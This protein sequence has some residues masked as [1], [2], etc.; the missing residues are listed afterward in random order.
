MRP[1]ERIAQLEAENM[2]QREQIAA[3][4]VR[5]QELEARLAKDSHNSSKP[6]SSDGLARKAKS[7]RKRS[8]K[9]AGGQIGHR[10]QT[11]RLVAVP[12]EIVE[13]RP[14]VCKACQT[15]LSAQASVVLR[16]RR[17]IHEVPPLRLRIIE[18]QALHVCCPAC[19]AVS[20][21]AFPREAPSRVQYGSRLR[22]LVVYLVEHQLVP[23]AR[24]RAVLADLFGASLSSGTLVQWVQQA[25]QAVEPVELRLKQALQRV[26]VLH[27]D[28]TGVRR[29]GT[30]AW[31]HVASTAQLTHYAIH[32]KRG[33]EAT[34]E[35]GILPQFTG[36]S[37]HDGWKP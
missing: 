30:L 33:N 10:G 17:Q 35:I 5:V 25:A 32:S 13:H 19:R 24:V 29:A 12:D 15:R 37:V 28:E 7:L 27:S 16:E 20:V 22:A 14:V 3:L 31:A 34:E 36:V 2:R 1:E 11:L 4:L 23:Y 18:H 9:K 26:P 6:P 21:G 8:G